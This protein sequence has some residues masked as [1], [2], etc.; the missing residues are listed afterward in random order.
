MPV[1]DFAGFQLDSVRRHLIFKEKK[2]H[3]AAR[4]IDVLEAL[5]AR[6]GETVDKD[7]MMR[8]VWGAT[9]V[10]ENTLARNILLIRKALGQTAE[11][12]F[13]V[14]VAGRGYRFV[15]PVTLRTP[16]APSPSRAPRGRWI[17]V[18]VAAALVLAA[19]AFYAY[20]GLRGRRV[21]PP[22]AAS[23]AE[24]ATKN[25][26]VLKVA[27]SPDGRALIFSGRSTNLEG[28]Y[29]RDLVTDEERELL[30]PGLNLFMG[31]TISADG[32]S[33]YYVARGA[34]EAT[35]TLYRIPLA[36]GN[37]AKLF[38]NVE[39]PVSFS[40][41]GRIVFVRE[42]KEA[43]TS[44]LIISHP[45][46]SQ[47]RTLAWVRLPQYLDYPSWS[48]DDKHIAATRIGNPANRLLLFDAETGTNREVGGAWAFVSCPRWLPDG[49]HLIITGR[50]VGARNRQL[51]SISVPG[52]EVSGVTRDLDDYL[53]VSLS[54]DGRSLAAANRTIVT[55]L[56]AGPAGDLS[57]ARQVA[58][59][60]NDESEIGW[61][62]TSSLLF[63]A[64]AQG[65][66][67]LW[68]MRPDGSE[69]VRLSMP[70]SNYLVSS[71]RNTGELVFVNSAERENTNTAEQGNT[72]WMSD[73]DG[74]NARRLTTPGWRNN[75]QCSPDGDWITYVESGYSL[76]RR[77]LRSGSEIVLSTE[78]SAVG[79]ISPD[80]AWV[81]QL[82]ERPRRIR[83]LPANGG[84]PIH[85]FPLPASTELLPSPM[86]WTPDR[87]GVAYVDRS[88]G[89]NVWIQ[90][91][92][93]GA[94]RQY[95][96]LTQESI[97]FF[98]WTPDGKQF[99]SIR[100]V[101]VQDAVRIRDLSTR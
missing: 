64:D 19:G 63:S 2:I 44:R 48:P 24:K 21:S 43:G 16:P 53:D 83:I 71:C 97:L 22:F 74:N 89:S 62:P 58:T 38:A 26:G 9:V 99:A 33:I 86:R 75:P 91:V 42:D 69:K 49:R 70:G 81:A 15:C 84:E 45:D 65:R 57:A 27:L 8:A 4:A 29:A 100:L 79:V 82:A 35:G 90:P 6:A 47:A 73:S 50:E 92:A 61:T 72:I 18:A 94:P 66:G 37:P 1:Y 98:D 40:T 7:E 5:L 51:W 88:R 85:T 3:L 11:N 20:W 23:E 76:M 28:L 39:S 36:G 10:E 30:A 54:K 13:I 101:I 93:G 14:T 17:T 95:T 31:L 34:G 59:G 80:G 78:R 12:K 52:G 68:R 41:D 67:V 55:S 46:G 60:L 87:K 25:R 32:S 96:N 56:W 77:D